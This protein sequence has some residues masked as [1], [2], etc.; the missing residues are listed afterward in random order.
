MSISERMS[1]FV[2]VLVK[3]GY[4]KDV[5]KQYNLLQLALQTLLARS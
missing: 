5:Q 1:S 3:Q 2:F 4:T